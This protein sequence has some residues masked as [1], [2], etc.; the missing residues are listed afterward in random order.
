MHFIN[1]VRWKSSL[2]MHL[3]RSTSQFLEVFYVLKASFKQFVQ[4]RY[5]IS[6]FLLFIKENTVVHEVWMRCMVYIKIA[7][8]LDNTATPLIRPNFLDPSG[9]WV[10]LYLWITKRKLHVKQTCLPRIIENVTTNKNELWKTV[11]LT[12]LNNLGFRETAHLPL[13]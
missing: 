8:C 4:L 12:S 3:W 6:T 5:A 13:P 10:P 1:L 7:L 9:S 2:T 11:W